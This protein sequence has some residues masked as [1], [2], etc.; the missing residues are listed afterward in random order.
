[1]S[2]AGWGEET[3]EGRETACLCRASASGGESTFLYCSRESGS[4]Q[5]EPGGLRT[6]SISAMLL[7]RLEAGCPKQAPLRNLEEV[8]KPMG[9]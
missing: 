4:N 7:L 3:T 5:R 9:E 1:M 2:V 6:T 8:E